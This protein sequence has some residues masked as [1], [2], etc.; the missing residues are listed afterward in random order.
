MKFNKIITVVSAVLFS[1]FVQANSVNPSLEPL[2]AKKATVKIVK[3]TS[4]EFGAYKLEPMMASVPSAIASEDNIVESKG[5]MSIVRKSEPSNVVGKGTVVRH[6]LTNEL[7]TLTGNVTVLLNNNTNADEL[8]KSVGM[9]VVSIFPRTNIAIF[10][11]K[12]GNDLLEAFNSL[13]KSSLITESKVEVT[14][15]IYKAQ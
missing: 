8:A 1:G 4:A 12:Q 3:V 10:K 13:K 11:I 15:T 7:T 14:N 2:K 9:E 6:L 5:S